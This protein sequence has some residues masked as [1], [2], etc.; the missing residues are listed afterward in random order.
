VPW[1]A[2][3]RTS[4]AEHGARLDG[5]V[6]GWVALDTLTGQPYALS[7]DSGASSAGSRLMLVTSFLRDRFRTRTVLA[8]AATPARLAATAGATAAM[9]RRG[10]Y[11]GI[12]LD[13]EGHSSADLEA[14]LAVVSAIA[15]SAHAHGVSPVVVAVP[16]TDTASYPARDIVAAGAD[17]VLVMLYD[18]HWAGSPP[19]PIASPDWARLRLATRIAEVGA[20]RIV[21][22]LPLFG[23]HW[24]PDAPTDVVGYADALRI[25]TAAGLTLDRE[26]SSHT[27]RVVRPD[28]AQVWVADAQLLRVLIE[29]AERAGVR[30]FSLWRLGL[31]DPAVWEG[32]FR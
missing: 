15:D 8:L 17:L 25:A 24:R 3:S 21:V 14:L 28:S 16:A 7:A 19:G 2:R 9:A 22:G 10:G 26:P 11:E 12:V 1:D 4:A 32:T 31:E 13:F 29:D 5:L 27:L 18:E 30:R 6:S 20:S 23:Y